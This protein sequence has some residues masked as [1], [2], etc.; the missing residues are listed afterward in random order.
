[1]DK[2]KTPLNKGAGPMGVKQLREK[3]SKTRLALFERDSV[4]TIGFS[5]GSNGRRC[6]WEGGDVGLPPCWGY[7]WGKGVCHGRAAG[8]R[9]RVADIDRRGHIGALITDSPGRG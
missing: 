4:H 5:K 1:L 9:G 6:V 7:T 3:L 8:G 2:K